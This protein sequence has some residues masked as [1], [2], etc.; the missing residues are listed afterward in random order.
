V[1]IVRAEIW[2]QDL[3]AGRES[4]EFALGIDRLRLAPG[5]VVA[6]TLSGR[7]RLFEIGDLI[8]TELR[9]VKARSIDPEV[10]SVPLLASRKKLPAIP[11]PLGPV[12]VTVLDLPALDASTPIVLTRLAITA[13]PWPGSV[14]I[15]ASSDGA[16]FEIA[17][18]AAAPCAIGET[19]DDLPAGPTARWDR[20]NQLRV[21]LYGGAL[22]SI[23]DARVLEGGN[24]AA[25]RNADGAWEILQ[26]ANAELVDGQTWLLSRLLRGQ[27]GSEVAMT[28]PLPAGAPFVVLGAHMVPIAAGL[29]ALA[30]PMQLRIAASGRNH[31]DPVAVALTV[32]PGDTA[33]KPLAP[34]H[35][36]AHRAGDGIHISW[37]RRTR[38]DGDGWGVE[39]PLGEEVEAYMLEILSGGVVVRSIACATPQGLY[40]AADELA[41]FGTVQA[42]LHIR[43]A[44]LSAAVGRGYEV[45][46]TLAI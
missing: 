21:K 35:V 10:F 45:E 11:A 15:W 5:D 28:A 27:A 7:R 13:N 24:A 9:Q 23:S 25:V 1:R 40:A 20:G 41:D 34:V 43:V 22:V 16:S 39:V 30:R 31:D 32:M 37:I 44:Q 33:L 36:A 3:W 38:I 12:A 26:F 14:A 17:A 42:S 2:L 8:D 46:V 6:L 4:A 19:L 18:M 29:D